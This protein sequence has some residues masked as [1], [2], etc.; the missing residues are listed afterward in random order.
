[1]VFALRY[2]DLIWWFYI[3]KWG[4]VLMVFTLR[5]GDL[6]WWFYIDKWGSVLMAFTLRRGDLIWW[7]LRGEVGIWFDVCEGF[8]TLRCVSDFTPNVPSSSP[9]FIQSSKKMSTISF[10]CIANS[11]LQ[12]ELYSENKTKSTLHR[13]DAK[14]CFRIVSFIPLLI[15]IKQVVITRI[16]VEWH[17]IGDFRVQAYFKWL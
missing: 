14:N 4:S 5:C 16:A 2:G 9:R 13:C 17:V 15:I 6:I 8:F 7:L 11:N 12:Q 3:D 10:C 1:M